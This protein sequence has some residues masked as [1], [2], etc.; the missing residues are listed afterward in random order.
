V[1][2]AA[3]A[4]NGIISL[5]W[6]N[7]INNRGQGYYAIGGA[8]YNSAGN[9]PIDATYNWWGNGTN[10]PPTTGPFNS[11]EGNVNYAN[12]T[13]P[14]RLDNADHCQIPNIIPPTSTPTPT[15]NFATNTPQPTFTPTSTPVSIADMLVGFDLNRFSQRTSQECVN[16]FSDLQQRRYC[17][18]HIS[19]IELISLLSQ[20]GLSLTHQVLI[21]TIVNSEYVDYIFSLVPTYTTWL[22]EAIARRFY[23]VRNG[24]GLDGCQGDELYKFLDYYQ[25]S[26]NLELDGNYQ[27]VLYLKKSGRATELETSV[28]NI[29]I[30]PGPGWTDGVVIGKPFGFATARG[31]QE[32]TLDSYKACNP[33]N[34]AVIVFHNPNGTVDILFGTTYD[35]DG[36]GICHWT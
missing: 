27:E 22:N 30:S 14:N 2:G 19:I 28:N 15:V 31:V 29:L 32:T 25:V 8:V 12:W 16:S 24:C 18:I 3:N 13:G 23:S 4:P 17:W 33:D 6:S 7:F 20:N 35:T 34:F 11:V 26:T 1:K 10:P 5:E 36:K 9:R 21:E